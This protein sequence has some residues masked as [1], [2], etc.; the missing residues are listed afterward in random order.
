MPTAGAINRLASTVPGRRAA[1]QSAAAPPI[2]EPI[3]T[4]EPSPRAARKSCTA[5]RSSRLRLKVRSRI[6]PPDS[7]CPWKSNEQNG[8][9]PS[10]AR[11]RKK[12][13][14]SPLCFEPKPCR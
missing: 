3:S 10:R 14:F 7:P 5:A 1:C 2:E 13:A 6:L 4:T 9:P 8:M 12:S 11:A